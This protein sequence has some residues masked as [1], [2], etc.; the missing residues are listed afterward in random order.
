M[1]QIDTPDS[2]V[3]DLI[4]L[5]LL[6]RS[7]KLAKEQIAKAVSAPFKHR[8]THPLHA[9]G[10]ASGMGQTVFRISHPVQSS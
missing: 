8:R 3:K 6:I 9:C 4:D 5:L 7:G 1:R 10:T 2:C